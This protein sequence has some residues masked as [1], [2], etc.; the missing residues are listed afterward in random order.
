MPII[1]IT[2]LRLR[3]FRYLLPFVWRSRQSARQAQR[4]PGFIMGRLYGDPRHLTFWTATV[5]ES[6]SAMRAYR[7]SGAHHRVMPKL[8]HWCDEAAVAHWEQ[9]AC[10]VPSPDEMLARMRANGRISRVR[11]PSA[12]HVAGKIA[13]DGRQPSPGPLLPPA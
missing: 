11:H 3:G 13:G 7:G 1:A 2:R 12:D 6:E 5:W 4:A 10:E 9:A 8:A